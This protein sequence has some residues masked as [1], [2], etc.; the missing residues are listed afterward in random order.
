MAKQI[1]ED[2]ADVSLHCHFI[3]GA[4]FTQ[5]PVGVLDAAV[6]FPVRSAGMPEYDEW[7]GIALDNG[8][9]IFFM[10]C[11]VFRRYGGTGK[12]DNG[13]RIWPVARYLFDPVQHVPIDQDAVTG[14]QGNMLLPD[15]VIQYATDAVAISKSG[16]PRNGA[17]QL[18]NSASS[19]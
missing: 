1:L 10:D 4:L 14:F 16:M 5:T 17:A 19:S 15:L 8:L 7:Q 3:A 2:P 9:D 6:Q 13:D 12:D 18:G 11:A